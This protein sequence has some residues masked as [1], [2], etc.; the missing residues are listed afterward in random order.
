MHSRF[1]TVF[2]FI[3]TSVM[4]SAGSGLSGVTVLRISVVTGGGD[5]HLD[6]L[7][8]AIPETEKYDKQK[9]YINFSKLEKKKNVQSVKFLSKYLVK[10]VII[11][12][13]SIFVYF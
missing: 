2:S 3:F 5:W 12:H 4:T 11:V 6:K 8:P 13:S 7:P 10:T 1:E 9:L